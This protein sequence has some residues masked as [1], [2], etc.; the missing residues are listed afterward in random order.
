MSD[1]GLGPDREVGRSERVQLLLDIA[2]W[3]SIVFV[4][5]LAGGYLLYEASNTDLPREQLGVRAITAILV[6]VTGPLLAV[7]L[8]G[9]AE[10][11]RVSDR[12]SDAQDELNSS[13]SSGTGNAAPGGVRT[14]ARGEAAALHNEELLLLVRELRDISLLS[15]EQ[16]KMRLEAQGRAAI[17]VLQRE[18]P[19]LLREHNWIEA[20]NRVQSTRE[21]FPQLREFDVL[22]KQI[23]TMR[24]QVEAHDIE[25]AQR[26]IN[27]LVALGAWDRVG[28]VLRELQERHPDSVRVLEIAEGLRGQRNKAESEARARLMAQAQEAVNA[29]NWPA[30]LEAANALVQRFPKSPEAQALKMQLPVLRE[31]AQWRERQNLESRIRAR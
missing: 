21:R 6:I 20:R 9:L 31:N 29:R 11:I 26:Q 13:L 24:G 8:W 2:A 12:I 7:L 16:R 22:E 23:E 28:E 1:Y 30:A 4:G 25:S 19:S 14:L 17:E 10:L 27:D 5:V 18:V 3:V 15:D